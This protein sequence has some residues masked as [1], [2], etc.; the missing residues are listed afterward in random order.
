MQ[1]LILFILVLAALILGHELGHFLFA[2]LWGIRVDEFGLGF[3]PRLATL[4]RAGGTKFTLN[5]I[6]LGGFVRPAGEDDPSVPGG[7]ASAPRLARASVLFAGPGANLLLAFFAFT[8]AF[9]VASPDPN[10]VILTAIAPG[11]P[12]ALAG[13]LEGDLVLRVEETPVTGVDS[14]REA[15]AAHLGEPIQLTVLRDGAEIVVRITPRAEPPPGE[16]PVG[17]ILGN[18]ARAVGAPEAIREGWRATRDHF[19][20]VLRLPGQW[21]RGELRP[22]ETRIT[23]L[24]GIYDLLAWAGDV[25]RAS[26]RPFVTLH[27]IGFL[28]ASLALANLLPIPALDG[29]R[30]LFLGMEIVFGRRISPRYEGWAHAIGYALLLALMVY[31]NFQDF[32]NPLPLPR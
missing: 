14:L 29:G 12:A 24:K 4:F 26:Q 23:G 22:E 30:L 16:G 6:P 1:D 13:L 7:L 2:R 8:A 9:K 5:A 21:F 31:V 27:F 32:V 15:I 19:V 11:S 28:S 10:R 18:P 25:D 3:P 17:V 20:Q